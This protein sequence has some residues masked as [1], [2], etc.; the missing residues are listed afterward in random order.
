MIRI[1]GIRNCDTMKKAFAWLEANGLPWEFH[2][3]RQSGIAM[4]KLETWEKTLGWETLLNRRGTTW[5]KLDADT[6]DGIDRAG[7]LRLMQAQTSLIKRPV[8]EADGV[9]LCGFDADTWRQALGR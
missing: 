2:D 6:Q 5:R 1:Y 8:L 3:Y 4:A 7:A 9:L